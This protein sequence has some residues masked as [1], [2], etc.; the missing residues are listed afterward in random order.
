MKIMPT[1]SVFTWLFEMFSEWGIDMRKY[2]IAAVIFFCILLPSVKVSAQ[3]KDRDQRLISELELQKADEFLAKEENVDHFSIQQYVTD[4]LKGKEEFSFKLIGKQLMGYMEDQIDRQKSTLLRILALGIFAGIF[5][6]FAGTIGD[7]E[8]GETGF[9]VVFLLLTGLVSSGFY[10]AYQIAQDALTQLV[11]FMK[12]LVPSFSL[13]LCYGGGTHTSLLFYET[14]LVIM[15]LLEM[16]MGSILLPGVQIFFF[17]NIV[18]QL[19]EHRFSRLTG[20]IGS[21]LRWSVKIL[22]AVLIGYQGVQGLLVPVM[23]RVRNNAVWQTAK[24]MPGIGN[25]VGG[26]MD[27]ILGSGVLIKSAVGVGG[28]L[29]ILILC[30]YPLIKLLLYTVMYK[31]GGAL[32]QPVSD[33]RIIVVLQS[34]A[35]SGKILLGYVLAGALMFILSITIVLVSTNMT[36]M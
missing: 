18:N 5:V 19:A 17:L 11:D 22:F 30:L 23:D 24:G 2:W 28:V 6:H 9:Y 29:G 34:A 33:R 36:S 31:I 26:V 15:G 27:T 4:V 35:A 32:I 12:V 10:I 8:L 25:T 21:A 20:L 14:M 1:G 7:R 3:E 13:A 16:I